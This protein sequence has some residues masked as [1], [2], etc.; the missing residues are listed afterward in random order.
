MGNNKAKL[1]DINVERR[2]KYDQAYEILGEKIHRIPIKYVVHELDNH[3]WN[4]ESILLLLI[5]LKQYTMIMEYD[6]YRISELNTWIETYQYEI[7]FEYHKVE[8]YIY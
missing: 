3:K 1:L 6:S 2:K 7:S 4:S 8:K 5:Y